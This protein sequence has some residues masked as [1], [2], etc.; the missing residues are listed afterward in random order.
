MPVNA[1]FAPESGLPAPGSRGN[2]PALSYDPPVQI[3]GRALGIPAAAWAVGVLYFTSQ[4]LAYLPAERGR[5]LH[6]L[7]LNAVQVTVWALLIIPAIAFMKRWPLDGPRRLRHWA[8]FAPMVLTLVC[9]GLWAAFEISLGSEQKP[10]FSGPAY[11]AGLIRFFTLYFH[12]YFLTFVS[13][14]FAYY[15]Y[16]WRRRFRDGALQASR[17]EAQL[18]QA[19]NQALRMQIQ[20]HFL[21]NTLHSIS[22]LMHSDVE[23]A[24]RMI[25]RM[26][27]LLR[28][29]LDRNRHQEIPLSQELEFLS[30]YL[31]IEGIRFQDRLRV[32]VEVPAELR[33]ALV[34]TFILQPL[35]ENALKHGLSKR[36]RGGTVA[37]RARLDGGL[38]H[39]EVE[40]DGDGPPPSHLDGV[41]LRSVRERLSLLHG[42]RAA[43]SFSGRPG[44]GALAALSLPFRSAA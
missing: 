43:F 9:A 34:P 36:R 44:Q 17:L 21:F 38:L 42:D 3:K 37:I 26:G 5:W 32:A 35:V 20:P 40:D 6:L 24:D 8:A 2:G 31:E 28:T 39:L 41:G 33:N 11:T 29:S 27:D 12:F 4:D 14:L 19:Q 30:A 25:T 23:A 7:G 16:L 13:V 1:A 22:T 18:F 10:L 15:A